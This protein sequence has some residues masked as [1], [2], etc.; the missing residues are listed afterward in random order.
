MTASWIHRQKDENTI[1][2][3]HQINISYKFYIIVRED[4]EKL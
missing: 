1:V 3:I 2:D 4:K